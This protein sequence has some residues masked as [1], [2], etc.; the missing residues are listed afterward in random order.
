VA[1]EKDRREAAI[2]RLK[3]KRAFTQDLVAYVVVN[4]FLVFVWAMSGR[5]YFWPAWVMGAWGIGLVM[6]GWTAFVQ[7]PITEEEI[8]R[9]MS[10]HQHSVE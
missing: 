6:H 3:N 2:D 1:E 4:A 9:E 7:Q 10:R 8:Q 5:G